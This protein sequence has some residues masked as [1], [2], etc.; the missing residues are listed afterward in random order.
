MDAVIYTVMLSANMDMELND[1]PVRASKNPNPP[2]AKLP[3]TSLITPASVP[4]RGSWQPILT[5]ISIMIV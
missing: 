5:I 2:A 1:E 3:S 4:G